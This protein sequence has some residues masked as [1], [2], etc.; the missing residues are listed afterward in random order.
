MDTVSSKKKELISVMMFKC[1]AFAEEW[2]ELY[3]VSPYILCTACL[4]GYKAVYILDRITE[5]NH[6]HH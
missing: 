6:T 3:N 4:T 1:L 5:H 2:S